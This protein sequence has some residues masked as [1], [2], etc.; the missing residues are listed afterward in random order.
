MVGPL[1][2]G[3]FPKVRTEKVNKGLQ[4]E[5]PENIHPQGAGKMGKCRPKRQTVKISLQATFILFR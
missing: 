3:K 4:L 1:K 5:V 2:V